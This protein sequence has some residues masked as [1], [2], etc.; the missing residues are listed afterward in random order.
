MRYF[1]NRTEAGLLLAEKLSEYQLDNPL[2]LALPRGGVPVAAAIAQKFHFQMDLLSVKKIGAPL[3]AEF[4]IGAVSENGKPWLN[5]EVVHS[6]RITPDKLKEIVRKKTEEARQKTELFRG[7]LP[8]ISKKD[9]EVILIDDGIATGATV[10]VAIRILQAQ[11][12]KKIVIA[13]PVAPE[14]TLEELR[15]QADEVICLMTP[16]PFMAVGN[17]YHDFAQVSDQDVLE[18]LQAMKSQN[19]SQRDAGI[20]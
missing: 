19:E 12:A 5:E 3:N 17:F 18:I 13:V 20:W 1:T 9:R 14:S 2:I 16:E 6:L 7:Y 4:A 8:E 11:G 15:K 10:M